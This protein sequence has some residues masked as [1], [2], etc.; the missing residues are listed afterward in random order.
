MK[1][2]LAAA[3]VA[4]VTPLAA[5]AVPVTEGYTTV[6]DQLV[7][8]GTLQWD[9]E[10]DAMYD[11]SFA[12]A[13]TGAETDLDDVTFGFVG[14]STAYNFTDISSTIPSRADGTLP[15]LSTASPFSI[16]F[17]DGIDHNVG[18]TLTLF[19]SAMDTPEVPLPASGLL[20]VAG[21]GGVAAL[22]K[23]KQKA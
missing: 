14:G 11:I 20:L 16:F 15:A 17:S 1:N 12:V 13:G 21:L 8:G 19:A 10:P 2:L 6:T 9:F 7:P 5:W 23:R 22:R 3:A 4:I 18:I